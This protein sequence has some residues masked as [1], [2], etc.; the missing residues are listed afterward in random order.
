MRKNLDS[1]FHRKSIFKAKNTLFLSFL[2]FCTLFCG[3][4]LRA[5]ESSTQFIQ[6]KDSLV[7]YHDV[8]GLAPSEFYKIRVRSAA[9]NGQW[10]NCFANITRSL[11]SRLSPDVKEIKNKKE[12]YYPYVKD[13]SHTYANIEMGKNS[14]VEVEISAVNDTFK[15]KGS[16]FTYAAAHPARQGESAPKVEGHKVYFTLLKAGQITIDINGQMD[17]TNT[18]NGYNGPPI[19]SISIFANPIVA[20]PKLNDP[21]IEYV[22]PGTKPSAKLGSKTTLYFLPGVHDIGRGFKLSPNKNY[23]IPGDAIVY[24]SF[25]N[26]GGESADNVRIYGYG[27]LSGDRIKHPDHDPECINGDDKGW[28]MIYTENCKNF[29]VEGISIVN[30]AFYTINLNTARSTTKQTFC[31]WLKIITWKGNGDGIGTAH[32]VLDCFIR[33]QDDCCYVKGDRKRCVFWTDVNGSVFVLAGIPTERALVIEDCD[34]IYPRHCSTKWN[35]GRVFSKRA[36]QAAKSGTTKV[37]VTFRDIRISDKFQ[38]LETFNLISKDGKKS[39]GGFSGI[40]F[41]NITSVKTPSSTDNKIIGHTGG[42][43]EDITFDN[44]VLGG[45]LIKSESDFGTMGPNVINLNFINATETKKK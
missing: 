1:F 17:D 8:K 22:K 29:R 31:H 6:G 10:I 13:W 4:G 33:T 38:T 45:N 26:I 27:S 39:S 41:K 21:K 34:I 24:G 42:P 35:G 12:H 23:Y 11:Y 18:G 20:K 32:E 7:A 25:N 5:Q 19:H 44:V 36:E 14:T 43:W 15:I 9:T 30:S 2:S 40:T 3:T 28:K 37:D 16:Q